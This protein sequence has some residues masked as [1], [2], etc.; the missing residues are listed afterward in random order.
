MA[1][2]NRSFPL[3]TCCGCH[4][5]KAA[6]ELLRIT[7]SPEGGLRLDDWKKAPGRGAYV[8]PELGCLNL[9]LRKKAFSRVFHCTL[10]PAA[11]TRLQHAVQERLAR[12]QSHD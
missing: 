12:N 6:G 3:R 2:I 4:V 8:C 5:T 1:K 9:A 10:S 7:R 11:L